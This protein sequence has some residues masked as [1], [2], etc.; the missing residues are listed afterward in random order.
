[1]VI[2]EIGF[3]FCIHDPVSNAELS[4]EDIKNIRKQANAVIAYVGTTG[5]D[6][7]ETDRSTL[8]LPRNQAD[9]VNQIAEINPKTVAY[10]QAVGQVDVEEF[11]ENVPAI[12]WCTY[13]G[14]A[15][16]N[17]MARLL[18]GEANPSGK[19]TFTW[20]QDEKELP[21]IGDYGIRPNEE[22]K[23]RTYQYFTGK[24]S[25][26]FGHGLSYS[27]FAY[28]N[29]KVDKTMVTRMIQLLLRQM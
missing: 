11:K 9:L 6:S 21:H 22:S 14:Q 4:E 10:I 5:N 15:Q 26:P 24:V 23:G 28:S 2:E 12:F 17:A 13:N 25:Y 29:L 8:A 1:M 20:Y 16:G 7:A 19:L 3:I 18:F 27:S